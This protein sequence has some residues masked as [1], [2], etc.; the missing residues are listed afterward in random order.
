MLPGGPAYISGQ[1][2]FDPGRSDSAARLYK[3]LINY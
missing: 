3:K 2:V 1:A